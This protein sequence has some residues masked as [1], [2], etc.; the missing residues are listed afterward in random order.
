[1]YISKLYLVYVDGFFEGITNDEY[2][3]CDI[4]DNAVNGVS[5][6]LID[7]NIPDR[8]FVEEISINKHIDL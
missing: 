1:M 6:P 8:V 7:D 3:I 2:K 4:A 5:P